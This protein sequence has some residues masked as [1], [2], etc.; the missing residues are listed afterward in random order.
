MR[1][2]QAILFFAQTLFPKQMPSSSLNMLQKAH[3]Y[4]ILRM[5]EVAAAIH[6]LSRSMRICWAQGMGSRVRKGFGAV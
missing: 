5:V 4:A 1:P 3:A 2:K 6:P